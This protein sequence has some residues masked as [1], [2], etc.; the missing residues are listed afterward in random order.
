M[1]VQ[2]Q[3]EMQDQSQCSKEIRHLP[4]AGHAIMHL[5]I[6]ES[7]VPIDCPDK[8]RD[9]CQKLKDQYGVYMNGNALEKRMQKIFAK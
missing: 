6:V 3:A 8:S 4:E 1:Q 7:A 5:Q 9:C 2:V